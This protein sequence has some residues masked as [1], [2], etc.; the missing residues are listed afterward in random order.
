MPGPNA[1]TTRQ[2]LALAVL[3]LENER[4]LPAHNRPPGWDNECRQAINLLRQ[5]LK[6][7]CIYNLSNHK[8]F[9]QMSNSNLDQLFTRLD[10]LLQNRV[11]QAGK[12]LTT[13]GKKREELTQAQALL[14]AELDMLPVAIGRVAQDAFI[15]DW[16]AKA[17]EAQT[18][19]GEANKL[20]AEVEQV[21]QRR[22][23]INKTLGRRGVAPDSRF[24][25]D[26]T[27]DAAD[28]VAERGR[29]NLQ[30]DDL[31]RQIQDIRRIARQYEQE[32][33]R[34]KI[35]LNDPRTWQGQAME[36]GKKAEAQARQRIAEAMETP[37]L[38][39]LPVL[40]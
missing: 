36:A 21:Q 37:E 25:A 8:E 6:G 29:L 31:R 24:G 27:G 5:Q 11:K 12:Y 32:A 22:L 30:I 18:A 3:C 14:L 28:L 38:V 2:A 16:Q 34:A 35:Q 33:Q 40:A 20:K 10:E 23:A 9:T 17:I 1:M 39:I 19:D 15:A 13:T 4:L 7:C 26:D